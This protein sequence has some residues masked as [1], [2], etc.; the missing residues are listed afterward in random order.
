MREINIEDLQ[1][2]IFYLA[3]DKNYDEYRYQGTF[4]GIYKPGPFRFATFNNAK[5]NAG[6]EL[7][8][9]N[10]CESSFIFYKKDA[11]LKAYTNAALRQITGDPDFSFEE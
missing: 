2:G 6:E 8:I 10:L 11:F 4:V 9:L 5:N 7:P 3:K 1:T